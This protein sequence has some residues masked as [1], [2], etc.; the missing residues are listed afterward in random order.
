MY[1]VALFI[2]GTSWYGKKRIGISNLSK[3]GICLEWF[4]I[5]PNHRGKIVTLN[6]WEHQ[7]IFEKNQPLKGRIWYNIRYY[8]SNWNIYLPNQGWFV[9]QDR[10]AIMSVSLSWFCIT[11]QTSYFELFH[12]G[13]FVGRSGSVGR[14]GALILHQ[15]V[16]GLPVLQSR[17]EWS[18]RVP[19]PSLGPPR[20]WRGNQGH[21][22][23]LLCKYPT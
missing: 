18:L 10:Q 5:M 1:I 11:E 12:C 3:D 7:Q 16:G 13:D 21:L 22:R 19:K 20:V 9:L 17:P 4:D 15:G 8:I 23:N 14:A 2:L 6:F